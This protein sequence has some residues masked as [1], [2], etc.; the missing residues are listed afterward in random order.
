MVPELL[1]RSRIQ[2]RSV[3]HSPCEQLLQTQHG[4][5]RQQQRFLSQSLPAMEPQ[6]LQALLFV[7]VSRFLLESLP[8]KS[9]RTLPGPWRGAGPCQ[10]T[11][12]SKVHNSLGA[13][14]D[15]SCSFLS[16]FMTFLSNAYMRHLMSLTFTR[17]RCRQTVP[18]HSS[19]EERPK[20]RRGGK[21]F[22]PSP[23]VSG[24]ARP[25]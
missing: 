1:V 2:R 6:E 23:T 20:Y 3:L 9:Q 7:V 17:A 15:C 19:K 24:T 4:C 8:A 13:L 11:E 25:G 10:P 21:I 16:P 5:H 18:Q 14:D 12:S 22:I